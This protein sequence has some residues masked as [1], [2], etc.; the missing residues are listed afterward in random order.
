[1]LCDLN[2]NLIDL[3]TNF[4]LDISKSDED[5]YNYITRSRNFPYEIA[6]FGSI[7]T[8]NKVKN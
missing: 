6:S 3:D 5:I 4:G 2:Y 1:M 8:R 7:L